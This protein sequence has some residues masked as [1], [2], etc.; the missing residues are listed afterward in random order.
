MQGPHTPFPGGLAL[1]TEAYGSRELGAQGCVW[2]QTHQLKKARGQEGTLVGGSQLP[3]HSHRLIPQCPAHRG[4]FRSPCDP[5]RD[6]WLPE[7]EP[8]ALRGSGTG[9][10]VLGE[11]EPG[12]DR[13]E[14]PGPLRHLCGRGVVGGKVC[15]HGA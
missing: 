8:L 5:E 13:M 10:Q 14:R 4:L 6:T 11:T 3:R 7:E 15:C 2:T 12:Y 9:D 1:P